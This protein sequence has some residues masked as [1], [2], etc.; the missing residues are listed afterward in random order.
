VNGDDPEACVR[1]AEL[2]FEYRQAFN[3]DVVIDMV[4]YR[5]RGHNEGDDPS[6][7]QPLM[8]NLIEA[9][10]SVR[11]LYTEALIGRGDISQDE[12]EAALRDYQSQLERVFADTKAALSQ[13]DAPSDPAVRGTDVEGHSGL[14][15][16]TAQNADAPRHSSSQ[17]AISEDMLHRIGDAF[18]DPPPGFTVHPKLAQAMEK[19]TGAV[20][21]GGIDWGFGELIAFGSLLM[22]GTPVRL[23]GQDS[24]RGTFVQRHAVLIDK[25]TAGEWTPL[26][27]LSDDQAKLWVYDSLLSE[28]AAMGFEYGYSVERPDASCSGR[29]SS[30]TSP[31]VRK[32]S[33]M[34]SSPPRSRS[35]GSTPPWFCSCRTATRA[36]AR[37]TP[38][39]GSSASCSCAPRT[40]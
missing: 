26:R 30:V 40:I 22:E 2:A 14:E 39:P 11:K 16:P 37:T 1:V 24:R 21:E 9:K 28:Y 23:A 32:P 34:S 13:G 15:R 7:T 29:P 3:K 10:R 33:S 31:M 19:R 18:T 20:R 5:R 12:A 25:E 27:Y 4:C 36:R 6:L 35:G 17:T 38:V 8:Y